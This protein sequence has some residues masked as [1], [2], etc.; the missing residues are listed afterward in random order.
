MTATDAARVDA[1]RVGAYAY[2]AARWLGGDAVDTAVTVTL[3]MWQ[4]SH[5]AIE[6]KARAGAVKLARDMVGAGLSIEAALGAALGYF[7]RGR[8]A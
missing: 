3:V 2:E 6:G 5:G 8:A 4:G 7:V 1:V